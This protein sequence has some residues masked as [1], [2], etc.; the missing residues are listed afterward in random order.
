MEQQDSG[1]MST[2]ESSIQDNLMVLE[3]VLNGSLIPREIKVE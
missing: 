2:K 3:H 1:I